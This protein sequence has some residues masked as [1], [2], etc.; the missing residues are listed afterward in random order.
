MQIF[1]GMPASS[2]AW[3]MAVSAG[4]GSMTPQKSKNFHLSLHDDSAGDTS[5]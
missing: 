2:A 3:M 4:R 5:G 1:K